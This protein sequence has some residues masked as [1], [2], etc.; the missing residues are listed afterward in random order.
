MVPILHHRSLR[1]RTGVEDHT[2]RRRRRDMVSRE[3]CLEGTAAQRCWW[4][5]AVWRRCRRRRGSCHRR[6]CRTYRE[7]DHRNRST[8]HSCWNCADIYNQQTWVHVNHSM[9]SPPRGGARGFVLY[10][11][12]IRV[13]SPPPAITFVNTLTWSHIVMVTP[14]ECQISNIFLNRAPQMPPPPLQ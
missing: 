11:A 4:G 13:T 2:P 3:I 14:C 7:F 5:R 1:Q 10:V 12:V 8:S 9:T 6:K